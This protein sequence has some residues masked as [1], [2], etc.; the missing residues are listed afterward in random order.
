V[1]RG[2]L[3]TPA[4]LI[5]EDNE[6]LKVFLLN[7]VEAVGFVAVQARNAD[8]ALLVLASR[9]DIALLITNVVMPGSINGVEFA[10][11]VARRWPA[12]KI[13]VASGQP[14][15]AESDL[16]L[17]SLLFA[18]PYH[19]EEMAFEIRSL[20]ATDANARDARLNQDSQG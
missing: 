14:G 1:T 16:P 15:L 19:E 18:K 6:L 2:Q 17:K 11:E 7:L 10:H 4:I 3:A 12:V 20:M 8:E 5:I 13:I 9:P